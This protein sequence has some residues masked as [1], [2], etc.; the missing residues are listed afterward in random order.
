MPNAFGQFAAIGCIV[1]VVWLWRHRRGIG[2]TDSEFWI[3]MWL[4]LA[5]GIG[6][7]KLLFVVLGWEHYARGEL[8]LW[9]DF[10]I[11]FVFWLFWKSSG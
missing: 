10:G 1:T 9:G 3:A 5:G 4:L 8:R 7:A 2:V 11:G 6:G